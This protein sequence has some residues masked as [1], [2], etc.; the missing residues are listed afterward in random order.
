M[1]FH[2]RLIGAALLAFA[3]SACATYTGTATALTPS[4]LKSEPG[5]IAVDDVPL[6]RQTSEYD[7]G[8]AAL[9]MVLGYHA[10]ASTS[11]KDAV[12]K[13]EERRYA[14]G[15]LRDRARKAGYSAFVIEGTLEDIKHELANGRPIIAGMAKPTAKGR[16]SHYEVIVG[17]HVATRRIAT[18]DPALGARENSLEGFVHEWVPTG[19]LLLI[20]LPKGGADAAAAG[21][22]TA[23]GGAPGG[24]TAGGT[25]APAPPASPSSS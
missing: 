14:A 22:G 19:Q 6:V 13:V 17:L 5:W 9:A 20:V 12:G 7:C 15:E 25:A 8:P 1:T 3:S 24:G 2:V 10:D 23:G 16:V 21:G 18:L 11:A 4:T